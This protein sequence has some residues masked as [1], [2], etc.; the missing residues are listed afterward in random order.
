MLVTIF[1]III[2]L[3]CNQY[4]MIFPYKKRVYDRAS[5]DE[6]D[7]FEEMYGKQFS[8]YYFIKLG[9]YILMMLSPI[10]FKYDFV[11]MP[12][13][14]V[15][16]CGLILGFGHLIFHTQ[17]INDYFMEAYYSPNIDLMVSN[18]FYNVYYKVVFYILSK[19][20]INPEKRACFML[21]YIYLKNREYYK[22]S[23]TSPFFAEMER[24]A[25]II[26][27]YSD[28]KK[29]KNIIKYSLNQPKIVNLVAHLSTLKNKN[30]AASFFSDVG[31]KHREKIRKELQDFNFKLLSVLNKTNDVIQKS[32][33]SSE[34]IK[35]MQNIQHLE[36]MYSSFDLD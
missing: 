26:S 8:I 33:D 25:A 7:K 14:L 17:N 34:K 36:S 28:D 5:R 13:L 3:L 35:H 31:S 21:N 20:S 4:R 15:F 19:I 27:L 10:F 30:L 16:L 22:A 12:K 1:S 32:E 29:S 24:L 9:A 23:D 18:R 6:E 2:I 11:T